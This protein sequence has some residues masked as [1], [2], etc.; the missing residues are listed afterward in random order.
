M[1]L[2][3]A[4]SVPLQ[5]FSWLSFAV[6]VV[7]QVVLGLLVALGDLEDVLALVGLVEG[8]LGA[9]HVTGE[10]HLGAGGGLLS[11]LAAFSALAGFSAG[12]SSAWAAPRA[13]TKA[14]AGA[15]KMAF[16]STSLGIVW[17]EAGTIAPARQQGWACVKRLRRRRGGG[18]SPSPVARRPFL[19]QSPLPVAGR[20]C[21]VLP[22]MPVAR[23]PSPVDRF[24]APVG[25]DQ[26]VALH[27]LVHRTVAAQDAAVEA[28]VGDG[29]G[30]A[31]K[32]AC[33]PR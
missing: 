10:G 29:P 3:V 25:R 7:G 24:P 19:R 15:Q 20:P 11:A 27:H 13:T 26:R 21:P 5:T 16:M 33:W 23:R 8:A 32:V 12:F 4:F 31:A 30:G 2:T 17:G 9:D 18:H 28:E 1:P 14:K 22:S 6:V